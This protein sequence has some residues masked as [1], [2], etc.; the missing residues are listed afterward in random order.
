MVFK[1]LPSAADSFLWTVSHEDI[2][3]GISLYLDERQALIVQ[4]S[5]I[6]V[7]VI[8]NM[9]GEGEKTT[10]KSSKINHTYPVFDSP[11][12]IKAFLKK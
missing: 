2:R 4:G 3:I 12:Q 1:V 10:E 6:I 5:D 8:N 11:D 7:S 9:F